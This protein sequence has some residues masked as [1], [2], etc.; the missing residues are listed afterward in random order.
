MNRA[1]RRKKSSGHLYNAK[2]AAQALVL[3]SASIDIAVERE[4]EA[5]LQRT[6]VA[7]HEAFGFGKN[8]IK[9]YT[10]AMRDVEKWLNTLSDEYMRDVQT[11]SDRAADRKRIGRERNEYVFEKLREEAQKYAP[12]ELENVMDME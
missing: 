11:A 4:R 7:L 3:N 12:V 1:Q 6:V 9:K 8:R 10:I 2:V 5:M